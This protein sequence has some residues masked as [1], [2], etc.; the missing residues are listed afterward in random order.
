MNA[1]GFICVAPQWVAQELLRLAGFTD[2]R[3]VEVTDADIRRA[4]GANTQAGAE[5][6]ARGEADFTIINTA[7]VAP[8]LD[9]GVPIT[10]IGGV[11]VG[12]A[13]TRT[14]VASWTSSTG[15]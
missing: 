15:P 7:Q 1:K 12:C 6:S 5:M 2:I 8:T 9:A 11:H 13:R 10:V 4:E 3:Y 14:S